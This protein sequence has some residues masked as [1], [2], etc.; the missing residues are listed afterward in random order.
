MSPFSG[1]S[2]FPI[3]PADDA[4]VVDTDAVRGLVRRLVDAGVDSIGLL[5][6]TGS[7]PY[8]SAAERR[9]AIVAAADE[10]GGRVPL[11]VGI[12]AL[13]TDEAARLAAQ[14]RDAGAAAGLLAPVSYTPLTDEEVFRHFEAVAAAAGMPICI[15]NNPGTT[16]FTVSPELV[17]RLSALPNVAAVKNPAPPPDDVARQHD[18]LRALVPRPFAL[19]YSAD[20]N[21]PA[22]LLAGGETWY[23]V[24]GG[25][26]PGTCLALTRAAMRGDAAE[27]HRL[28]AA[29]EPLWALFRA[30]SSLRVVYA[31]ATRLG[32]CRTAPPRPILPLSRAA[33]DEVAATIERLDLH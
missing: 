13:R 32:L 14:A 7:Y 19:G 21:V 31:V 26:F 5:G 1:L 6:S 16:H 12:G 22:A 33:Q 29:L 27:T 20:W 15:Y 4:G 25:L 3:T 23:S 28:N 17:L 8:L 10:T 11:L 18:A 9:R 24:A 2:A 30:H